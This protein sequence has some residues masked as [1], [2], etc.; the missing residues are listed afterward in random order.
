M[1]DPEPITV[2]IDDEAGNVTVDPET[3]TIETQTEDGGVVVQLDA[4]RNA[5]AGTENEFYRN[6]ADELEGMELGKI[7]NDIVEAIETTLGTNSGTSVLKHFV[8]GEFPVRVTGVAATGTLQQTVV[9]GTHNNTT[10]GTSSIVGGSV[11]SATF[12]TPTLLSPI[13]TLSSDSTGD[14]FYR[15]AGGTVDRLGIGASTHVLTV[16]GGVPVWS[17]SGGVLTESV[18]TVISTSATVTASGLANMTNTSVILSVAA[19]S[20]LFAMFTAKLGHSTVD[21]RIGVGFTL[22]GTAQGATFYEN[23]GIADSLP[24][25][26][27]LNCHMYTGTLAAITGTFQVQWENIDAVGSAYVGYRELTVMELIG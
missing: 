11:N 14:L 16:S 21:K 15:A 13:I 23:I 27:V 12:G 4:H 1:S 25:S 7:A 17:A 20:R 10:L 8:A 3:G 9:G 26:E 24:N 2:T 19:N 5:P 18:G 6:L 22:N